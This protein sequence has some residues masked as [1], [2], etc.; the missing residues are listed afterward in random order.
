MTHKGKQKSLCS[1][2]NYYLRL[3]YYEQQLETESNL[4]TIFQILD[5]TV[6]IILS[7][8]KFFSSLFLNSS[9]LEIFL[10][11]EETVLPDYAFYFPVIN[12]G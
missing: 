4:S 3:V 2:E 12:P 7:V 8:E 1:Y 10:L 9:F 11:P 5:L 6:I